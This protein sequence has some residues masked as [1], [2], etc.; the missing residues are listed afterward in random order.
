M[1]EI[2]R[3]EYTN[4]VFEQPWW[5]DIVAKDKWG[6]VFVQDGER[7]VARMPYVLDKKVLAMP[8]YT[9][10]LGIWMQNELR[11]YQNGNS[12]LRRQ[13]EVIAELLKSLPKH[14]SACITLDSSQKYV[15][16]FRWHGYKIEPTFSYRI[17]DLSDINAVMAKMSKSA[18]K[19]IK[20]AEKKLKIEE[21][22]QD[23]DTFIC[24]QD[25]SYKRQ[26]R[27]NPIDGDLTRNVI[28][29]AFLAGCGRLMIAYGEDGV[30][31]SGAF[32]LY[33]QNA[34]YYLM[35]GQD[36]TYKNDGSQNLILSRAIAFAA[37]VSKCFDF[38]GSMVEGIEHFF[39]QFGGEQV[40][41]YRI[42]KQSFVRDLFDVL[43]P[44]VKKL[45]G[46]KN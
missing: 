17:S 5:L 6:E 41:N 2:K 23:I 27:K 20:Q 29:G 15:L 46:Y 16:P 4:N 28:Q 22:S 31:H 32:F 8:T 33:D 19:N 26:G 12:H 30:P 24:L 35:G 9:Q 25:L 21:D 43:K 18:K 13:K 37:T 40:V 1:Q 42:S 36:P 45:L 38:E 39:S 44:R 7:I 11:E 14:K 34:C 3:S 10:T